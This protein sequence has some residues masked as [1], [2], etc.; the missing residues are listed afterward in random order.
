[1]TVAR[2]AIFLLAAA[3]AAL[4]DAHPGLRHAT[5]GRLV[6]ASIEID[7]RPAPLYPAPDS[8]GRFYVE[9]HEGRRYAIVLANRSSERLGVV[10]TVDGLNVISGTRGQ[11]RGRMYVLDPWQRTTVRGWRTSLREVRQFTFVDERASYAARSGKAN[12][13]MGW[14]ELAVYR[15]RDTVALRTTEELPDDRFTG[16]GDDKASRG[17]AREGAQRRAHSADAEAQAPTASALGGRSY[18]GTG[19][20][21]RTQD[22]AVLVRFTP[23]THASQRVTLR[24]E[25][26]PAL[27][28]LG[29]LPRHPFPGDRLRQRDH[30]DVGFAQPPL[31]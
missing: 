15:E 28:A 5:P 23:E 25:Y 6:A 10:L 14:I 11:G 22:R 19:W 17:P 30:A 18:P 26:R 27:V 4:A 2:A 24:Y 29:V 7:G 12:R 13:K 9:A 31:W 1:M 3:S 21:R 20:G 16:A 8:S